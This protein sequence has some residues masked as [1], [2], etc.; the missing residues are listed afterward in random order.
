MLLTI[1]KALLITLEIVCCL[2]LI[3]VI[4]LQRTKNQG[5]GLAFGA[6]MG[7]SLFGSQVGNVLTRTTVILGIIFLVNTAVLGLIGVRQRGS[8]AGSVTDGLPE[9][10]AP[11]MPTAPAPAG[12]PPVQPP[13]DVPPMA[14]APDVAVPAVP[15][16]DVPAPDVAVPDVSAPEVAVPAPVA[17]PAE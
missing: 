9:A 2:M 15:A 4:L 3:G 17:P 10:A 12:L 6:G 13:V 8:A 14:P 1:I 11:V 5:A 7:E 16:P